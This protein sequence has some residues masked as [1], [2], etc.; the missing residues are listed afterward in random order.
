[1]QKIDVPTVCF[2]G[3]VRGDKH[4]E[5][6][7]NSNKLKCTH[8][9]MHTR[10]A[11][12]RGQKGAFRSEKT[13]NTHQGGKDS[14]LGILGKAYIQ[15]FCVAERQKH[16][17]KSEFVVNRENTSCRQPGFEKKLQ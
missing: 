4:S 3:E 6:L 15:E 14:E 17:L 1:M 5:A 13:R 12:E 10:G 11:I 16:E 2:T 8:V 9:C 7:R